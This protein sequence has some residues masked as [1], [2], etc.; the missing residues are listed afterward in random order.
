[1]NG[2]SCLSLH[3]RTC[4]LQFLWINVKTW[5]DV[6]LGLSSLEISD[7]EN[8]ASIRRKSCRY[9]YMKMDRKS[10]IPG[11]YLHV[12][13]LCGTWSSLTAPTSLKDIYFFGGDAKTSLLEFRL[14][15]LNL[16]LSP[17]AIH[18]IE[19]QVANISETYLEGIWRKSERRHAAADLGE[20]FPLYTILLV[21]E[22]V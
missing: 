12:T 10:L 16:I 17:S 19:P 7:K 22:Q 21:K 14:S 4:Q 3:T 8:M 9:A 18:K 2:E 11:I 1:M 15:D 6:C 5:T 13:S 20:S